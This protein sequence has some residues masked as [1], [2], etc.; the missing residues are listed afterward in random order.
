MKEKKLLEKAIEKWGVQSQIF[1]AIEE[2]AELTKALSKWYRRPTKEN[3]SQVMEE[4]A[5]V[6]IMLKQML[7]IFSDISGED[8]SWI[9][10]SKLSRLAD[11]LEVKYEPET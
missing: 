5:D 2:M 11:M 10:K 9:E 3:S 4:I 7:L 8:V 6:Q 1:M